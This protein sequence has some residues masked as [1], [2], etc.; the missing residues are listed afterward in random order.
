MDLKVCLKDTNLR[1]VL[2]EKSGDVTIKIHFV[3]RRLYLLLLLLKSTERRINCIDTAI[4]IIAI[5][6]GV[7][8]KDNKIYSYLIQL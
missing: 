4:S 7:D 6:K 3:S 1:S 5:I 2:H 8:D